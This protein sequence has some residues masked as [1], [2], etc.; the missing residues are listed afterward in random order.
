MNASCRPRLFAAILLALISM[1]PDFPL[2]RAG[3]SDEPSADGK[4]GDLFARD[5][6]IAWCIV[7][8]DSK[9]REPAERAEMLH[10]L[11]FRHF[12]YDWRA[13]HIP[14]F[15]AEI[16]ALKKQGVSLDAFWVAPG[17]V[18]RES[19]LIL[20]TL[21]RHGVKAQLWVLLDLGADRAS[22]PEQERRVQA[23]ADKLAPLA[24]EAARANCSLALYNHGGWFGE[25]ENQLAI[26]KRLQSQGVHNVGIV[27]NLHHGHEHLDRLPAVLAMLKPHL[28]AI[29][30]NGMDPQGDRVGRKI[31]PLGQGSRDLDVLR[32]VRDSGYRGP[33]GILGHT[34]DDAEQRL[35][36]NLDGLD[37]LVPQLDGKP[38]GPRPTP[39]T[40]V[41][42]APKA[43]TSATSKEQ[44]DAAQLAALLAEA[45]AHGD[46]GR[47]AQVIASPKFACLSCHRVGNQG[48]TIGP[49]LST[50]GVCVKPEE[51]VES[52]LWPAR[53]VK[54]G[55]QVVTVATEDGR[56]VQGYRQSETPD[57]L[58][59]RDP[60]TGSPVRIAR[61][62]IDGVRPGGTLMPEGLAA[63]MTAEERRDLVRFLI[64]LGRP[65]GAASNPMPAHSHAPASFSYSRAPIHPEDWPNRNHLV[66]RDRI[67]DFYA[68]EAEHFAQ[69][70]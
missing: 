35:Q 13:E 49:D 18:N 65:G 30:L 9:K 68:K 31:L 28:V 61:E 8:F 2:A 3:Q 48:G 39:R 56:I 32:I 36:D 16:A 23:A 11:G 45:Q 51:I 52:L 50:V 66:N 5:N 42:P 60:A 41:P 59:L 43:Q 4:P 54:E 7:P 33:I 1:L 53:K 38:P 58:T 14:T 26:L 46:P 22:G 6:L 44:A 57:T 37:W 70:P 55:Y 63:S 20:D 67:Y 69:E 15:D 19:R 29:N 21:A 62:E 25:P 34:M 17:E 10:R 47:G 12:A 27:Y 64:E 40:P 24:K